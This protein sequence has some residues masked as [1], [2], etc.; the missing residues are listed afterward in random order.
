MAKIATRSVKETKKGKV[1]NK[2]PKV[3]TDPMAPRPKIKFGW[4][5]LSEPKR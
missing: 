2:E 3:K 1:L 4:K 5:G